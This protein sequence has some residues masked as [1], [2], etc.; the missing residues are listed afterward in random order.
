[1]TGFDDYFRYIKSGA[2]ARDRKLLLTAILADAINLGPT[3]MAESCTDVTYPKLVRLRATNLRDETYSAALA[4][5][6]NAQHRHPLRQYWGDVTTSSSDG[7]RFRTGSK[8]AATGHVNP[9]YG[10]TPGRLIYTHISGL[11]E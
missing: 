9:K 8:A 7:Q 10:S 1:M 4:A 5:I 2:P 3:K 11:S 6:V